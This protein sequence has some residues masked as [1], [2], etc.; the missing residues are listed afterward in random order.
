[1]RI[2][3][4]YLTTAQAAEYCNTSKKTLENYRYSGVG[5]QYIKRRKLLRYR[6][7]DLDAWMEEAIH[8]TM[9]QTY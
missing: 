7:E 4:R 9:D 5:P 8:K 1:M 6:V 2:A 3:P